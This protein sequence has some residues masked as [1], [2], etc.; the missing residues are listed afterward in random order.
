MKDK[1]I[2]ATRVS[3]IIAEETDN[4]ATLYLY[5]SQGL[6]IGMKYRG[7]SYAEDAWDTFW[8]EKNLQGDIVAVYD[9][10]GTLYAT[11]TYDAWG[12]FS[13]S[14]YNNADNTV[15]SKNPF[16]FNL[17]FSILKLRWEAQ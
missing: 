1:I 4:N 11:Y 14:Y 7:A 3:K 13:V 9:A 8:F 6:P 16:N 15:V 17:K 5:D 12:L 10:D 2:N